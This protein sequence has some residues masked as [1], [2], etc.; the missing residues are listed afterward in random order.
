LAPLKTKTGV[1]VC[2]CYHSA[3]KVEMGN[4]DLMER[5]RERLMLKK[6]KKKKKVD[7]S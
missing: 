7:A 2:S 5:F 6:K 3:L 1:I 4:G